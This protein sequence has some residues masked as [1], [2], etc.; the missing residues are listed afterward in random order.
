MNFLIKTS[1]A[2][3][4]VPYYLSLLLPKL[5]LTERHTLLSSFVSM[6]WKAGLIYYHFNS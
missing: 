5:S 2:S 4:W 3:L 1:I 6:K